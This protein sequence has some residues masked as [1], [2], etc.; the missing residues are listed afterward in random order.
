MEQIDLV[1]SFQVLVFLIITMHSLCW[2]Y[3]VLVCHVWYLRGWRLQLCYTISDYS[4]WLFFMVQET[5]P[6]FLPVMQHFIEVLCLIDFF[7]SQLRVSYVSCLFCPLFQCLLYF[8]GLQL[9]V[10][11]YQGLVKYKILLCTFKNHKA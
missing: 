6:K 4:P 11:T 7:A 3:F 8:C 1:C 2:S 10:T 5:D 9:L